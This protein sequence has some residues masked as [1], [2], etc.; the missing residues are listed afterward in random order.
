MSDDVYQR[1]REFLDAMPAGYP[2][3]PTGV[4]IKILKKIFT[5]E[6]AELTMQLTQEPERVSAIAARIGRDEAELAPILEAM[7]LKGCIY[8]VREGEERL[9]RA[10]QFIVGIY[11]F[12]LPHLDREFCELFEEYFPHIAMS[13]ADV[14]TTQLRVVPLESSVEGMSTVA[15]YNR[16]R[17]LVAQQELI[18]VQDCICRKE[19]E[20]LDNKCDRPRDL[21]FTFGEF[22]QYTLDNKAARQITTE[23][24]FTLLDKAEESALVVCPT[25]SENIQALCCCCPCCCGGLKLAKMMDRPADVVTSY[26]V[27]A[28]DAEECTS[29]EACVERCQME[30]IAETDDV[31]AIVDGRC[32]GCGLCIASCPTEAI[33]MIPK[34]GAPAPPKEFHETIARI[35]V[36][37]GVL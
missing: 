9:Y 36:E 8:R 34:D 24:A 28:I 18:T 12:Q 22:A 25:N 37:R 16:V 35:G 26:Y 20:L 27:A 23:E 17:E 1:L 29:C 11:E 31:F 30:A 7:A 15:P 3:T 19:Q 32:I 4:E 5:P 14:K 2:A 10:F 13:L 33:A 21:C 6:Y